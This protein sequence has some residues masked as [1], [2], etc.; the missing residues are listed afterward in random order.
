MKESSIQRGLIKLGKTWTM[1]YT[2]MLKWVLCKISNFHFKPNWIAA[3]ICSPCAD[4]EGG[5]G[6]GPPPPPPGKNHKYIFF[7]SNTGPD[8]LKNHKA[9][10]PEFN[11]G[12]SS[13]R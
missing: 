3:S 10:K 12:P 2:S 8:P 5:R 6:S 1:H 7:L 11:V 4:P 13:A 9:T